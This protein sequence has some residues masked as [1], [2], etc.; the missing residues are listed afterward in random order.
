[1]YLGG[2]GFYWVVSYHPEK[3]HVMEVRRGEAGTRAWTGA[4]RASTT[5]STT[6]ELGGLWRNA[7][8]PPQR[9]FG[10]GF[11]A[12][13]FDRSS[14]Y[15]R[16]PDSFDP[17][18]A[19]SSRASATDEVIGDFG[20]VGG[21]AAGL[22][23]DRYDLALGTPP[24]ALLVATSTAALRQLPPLLGGDLRDAAR[25]AAAARIPTCAPTSSTSATRGGGAVFSTGSIAWTRQPLAQRLR[26]QRRAH[27]GQR[28][29][30]LRSTGAARLVATRR[31]RCAG[32]RR[33]RPRPPHRAAARPPAAPRPSARAG[34]CRAD[35]TRRAGP[36]RRR[37]PARSAP[38]R[39]RSA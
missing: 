34:G 2:N 4:A 27:H 22:E 17:R 8:R 5:I 16:M 14:P 21:G 19:S 20:L 29:A 12:Q 39:P 35:R 7:G 18:A 1:M 13:G 24:H 32:D 15:L 11:T 37:R 9:L 10:V 36:S 30:A 23:I 33:P 38:C 26:Q 28:A 3:P 6:G 25:H 31:A